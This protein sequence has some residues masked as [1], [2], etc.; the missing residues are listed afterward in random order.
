MRD[1][2]GQVLVQ[3]ILQIVAKPIHLLKID[4]QGRARIVWVCGRGL[5]Y[6]PAMAERAPVNDE[7]AGV[8]AY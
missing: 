8:K 3:Q 4:G 6:L 7:G 5:G 2:N 1:A